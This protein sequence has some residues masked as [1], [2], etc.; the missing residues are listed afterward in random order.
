MLHSAL[1]LVGFSC[2]LAHEMDAVRWGEWALLPVLSRLG[3]EAGYRAFTALHLPLYALLLWA[4]CG[5]AAPNPRLVVGLDLFLV[6]HLLLH[7]LL[8]NHPRNRF[9]SP[10]SWSL[11][12]GAAICGALDLL[13]AR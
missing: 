3:D 4:L 9:Q 12:A 8:R 2:L 13:L 11:F 7:L 6:I 10:F 5:P 1:F